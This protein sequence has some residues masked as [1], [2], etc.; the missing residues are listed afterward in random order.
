MLMNKNKSDPFRLRAK[1]VFACKFYKKT[2]KNLKAGFVCIVLST[3]ETA[4]S[5]AVVETG[6]MWPRH[7][8]YV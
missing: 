5:F 4:L 2:K 6:N 8:M 1:Q 3:S 7:T